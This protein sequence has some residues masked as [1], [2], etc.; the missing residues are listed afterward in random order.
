MSSEFPFFEIPESERLSLW[1]A[2][3][4]ACYLHRQQHYSHTHTEYFL[5]T[6]RQFL[7]FL[8]LPPWLVE[9][10]HLQS[11][12]AH[13]RRNGRKPSTLNLH[14]HNLK[15]FYQHCLSHQV[16][17]HCPPNFN[18]AQGLTPIQLPAYHAACFLT[19]PEVVRFLTVLRSDQSPLTLRD[20]ALALTRLMLGIPSRFLLALT[21]GDLHIAPAQVTFSYQQRGRQNQRRYPALAWQAVIAY[22]EASARLPHMQPDHYLFVPLAH[23]TTLGV[24]GH[25]TD[26]LPHRSL[27]SKI[28][29]HNF[30]RFA[31]LA[32]IHDKKVTLTCLKHTAFKLF[33]DSAATLS[34]LKEF[35][36]I[37]RNPE[38]RRMLKWMDAYRDHTLTTLLTQDPP[39]S[40]ASNPPFSRQPYRFEP[41]RIIT[42]GFSRTTLPPRLLAS[43]IAAGD[44]DLKAEIAGLTGLI[45][46]LYLIKPSVSDW[47]THLLISEIYSDAVTRLTRITRLQHQVTQPHTASWLQDYYRIA[48]HLADRREIDPAE[49]EN[50]PWGTNPS[51]AA[52]G[53]A[54][55]TDFQECIARI[56]L[57]MRQA[58]ENAPNLSDP[59][60]FAHLVD[61]YSLIGVKLANLLTRHACPTPDLETLR[62][63]SIHTALT[64]HVTLNAVKSL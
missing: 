25:H 9:P 61:H 37:Q 59:V 64:P 58:L 7:T 32:G 35:S 47:S 50:F 40:S 39:P 60:Q 38:V 19:R 51:Q 11:F 55:P 27:D 45:D 16:D 36:G 12:L 62:T 63:Q 4:Q 18:P 20:Y 42:H 54:S 56:R 31:R 44:R 23:S 14:I 3:F 26:W 33:A 57:L 52:P 2:A 30:D 22:L 10:S 1:R 24:T 17:P 6:W 46:R 34:Q 29:N 15:S 8:Q 13:L 48:Q 21:W 5:N 53:P 28:A 43:V 49:L 41:G